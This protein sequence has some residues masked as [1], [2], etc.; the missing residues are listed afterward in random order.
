VIYNLHNGYRVHVT[1]RGEGTEF[2]TRNA[3]GETISSV[4]HHGIEAARLAHSLRLADC[5]FGRGV[6]ARA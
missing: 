3:A 1:P 4:V 6:T 2:E 5:R